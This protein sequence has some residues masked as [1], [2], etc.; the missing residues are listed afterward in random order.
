MRSESRMLLLQ[1]LLSGAPL[2]KLSRLKST[3]FCMSFQSMPKEELGNGCERLLQFDVVMVL[4][5]CDCA[6][7]AA[8]QSAP[9]GTTCGRHSVAQR[10]RALSPFHTIVICRIMLSA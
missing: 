4:V 9:V 6:L 3:M 5:I 1:R 2:L 7:Q 10:S 8:L